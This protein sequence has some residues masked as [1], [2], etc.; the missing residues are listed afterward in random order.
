MLFRTI[1]SKTS[2]FPGFATASDIYPAAELDLPVSHA[3]LALF[4]LLSEFSENKV[5]TIWSCHAHS[6]SMQRASGKPQGNCSLLL[7][8]HLRDLKMSWNSC[9]GI[10]ASLS[11]IMPIW[12][13]FVAIFPVQYRPSKTLF[14]L[15]WKHRTN[16]M[17]FNNFKVRIMQHTSHSFFFLTTIECFLKCVQGYTKT[18]K[19]KTEVLLY[20]GNGKCGHIGS[21]I[22]SWPQKTKQKLIAPWLTVRRDDTLSAIKD[23]L[24][25]LE[26][27]NFNCLRPTLWEQKS[28][29]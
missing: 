5:S 12:L 14:V 23:E 6:L 15:I 18:L 19:H 25:A 26:V 4:I 11:K 7:L 13:T 20:D 2:S 29:S 27:V 9:C 8:L 3:P 22:V 1:F 21:N 28:Q 24:W 16:Y 10:M 17:S